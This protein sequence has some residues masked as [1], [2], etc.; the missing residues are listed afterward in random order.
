MKVARAIF[1]YMACIALAYCVTLAL[2]PGLESEIISCNL[3]SWMPVLLMFT[4]N[5]TDVIVSRLKVDSA[6]S[7]EA[8]FFFVSF[9]ISRERFSQPFHTLGRGGNSSSCRRFELF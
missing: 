6:F 4:F 5:T 3:K 1:P 8:K 2:Y 9:L 7:A